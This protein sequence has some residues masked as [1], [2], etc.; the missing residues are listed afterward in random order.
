MSPVF[1]LSYQK[2]GE[3]NDIVKKFIDEYEKETQ[4]A[5]SEKMQNI[6][7]WVIVAILVIAIVVLVYNFIQSGRMLCLGVAIFLG[8]DLAIGCY[9]LKKR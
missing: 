4:V 9:I 5:F 8:F 2:T 1:E 7:K 6:F 3:M